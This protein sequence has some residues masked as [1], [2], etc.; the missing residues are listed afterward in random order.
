MHA[1]YEYLQRNFKTGPL[2]LVDGQPQEKPFEEYPK[3]VSKADGTRVI[4]K[5]L[6]EEAEIAGDLSVAAR[7]ADPL[8][9]EKDRLNAESEKLNSALG[10]VEDLKAQMRAQLA[11]L[12]TA[13]Q[14]LGAQP[15]E[16]RSEVKQTSPAQ[17]SSTKK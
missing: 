16:V 13:R 9:A 17:T 12:E 1:V 8:A 5:S 11:E 2:H 3:W 7:P 15:K 6:R 4:V 14:A 10:E